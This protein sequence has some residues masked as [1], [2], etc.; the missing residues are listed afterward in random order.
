MNLFGNAMETAKIEWAHNRQVYDMHKNVNAALISVF[1]QAIDPEV[2]ADVETDPQIHQVTDFLTYFDQFMRQYGRTDA[3]ATE[4]LHEDMKE[5]WDPTV[6][7][8]SPNSSVNY[9]T[10]CDSPSTSAPQLQRRELYKW[11]SF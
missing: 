5:P 11:Q 2:I 10:A 9:A 3:L 6:P 4:K 1:R 7:W 8:N